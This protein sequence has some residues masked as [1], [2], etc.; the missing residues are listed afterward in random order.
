LLITLVSEE[1]G[2]IEEIYFTGEYDRNRFSSDAAP[3][4]GKPAVRKLTRLIQ[5][6]LISQQIIRDIGAIAMIDDSLDNAISCA[7]DFQPHLPVILFGPYQWNRRRSKFPRSLEDPLTYIERSKTEFEWW[8]KEVVDDNDLPTTVRRVFHW[9][10]V[11]PVIRG[12]L[13]VN[14]AELN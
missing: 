14:N 9:K 10:E 7:T 2:C 12:L 4:A 8:K 1:S 11:A 13:S 6:H 3:K 5:H